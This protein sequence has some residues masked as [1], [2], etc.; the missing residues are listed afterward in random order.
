MI[1]PLVESAKQKQRKLTDAN[2]RKRSDSD[3]TW[4]AVTSYV[5]LPY[6]SCALYDLHGRLL[7]SN[8]SGRLFC[9]VLLLLLIWVI[10]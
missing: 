4:E 6:T 3:L 7:P 9:G 2:L 1:D 5:V 8:P 10:F